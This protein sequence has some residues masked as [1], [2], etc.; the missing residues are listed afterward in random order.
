MTNLLVV[1]VFLL[2][3]ALAGSN[4]TPSFSSTSPSSASFDHCDVEKR[5]AVHGRALHFQ[6]VHH[7]TQAIPDA[8]WDEEFFHH[9]TPHGDLPQEVT[10]RIYEELCGKNRLDVIVAL[11]RP[12][13]ALSAADVLAEAVEAR[14]DALE[15]LEEEETREE[16]SEEGDLLVSDGGDP[17]IKELPGATSTVMPT[18]Q[19]AMSLEIKAP[20]I[21]IYGPVYLGIGGSFSLGS[22]QE[23]ISAGVSLGVQLGVS[24]KIVDLY[25][26]VTVS[27]SAG[28]SGLQGRPPSLGGGLLGTVNYLV[29]DNAMGVKRNLDE[30]V[31]SLIRNHAQDN[32]VRPDTA[33]RKYVEGFAQEYLDVFSDEW[34]FV[35]HTDKQEALADKIDAENMKRIDR[36]MSESPKDVP[37]AEGGI[38]WQFTDVSFWHPTTWGSTKL[39]FRVGADGKT[40]SW[41]PDGSN[42]MPLS[43]VVVKGG[44]YDG[45]R[46]TG[47][48]QK[49]IN[50]LHSVFVKGGRVFNSEQD[51]GEVDFSK[52]DQVE[53]ATQQEFLESNC[54]CSTE[55]FKG[56]QP[57]QEGRLWKTWQ[58][59]KK[60]DNEK[61]NWCYVTGGSK[62]AYA[63]EGAEG[64]WW[65][66]CDMTDRAWARVNQVRR[67]AVNT[68]RKAETAVVNTYHKAG[69]IVNKVV[70]KGAAVV[71][72]VVEKGKNVW[73]DWKGRLSAKGR[74]IWGKT[75]T[76]WGNF[77]AYA[78]AAAD[79]V[80]NTSTYKLLRRELFASST[81]TNPARVFLELANRM[82][83]EG[84]K[85]PARK[86]DLLRRAFLTAN[87]A[88]FDDWTRII[89]IKEA[90][91]SFCVTNKGNAA[92]VRERLRGVM[93][94]FNE[95][96]RH[97]ASAPPG[98][99]AEMRG[100]IQPNMAGVRIEELLRLPEVASQAAGLS[101][102]DRKNVNDMYALIALNLV[103]KFEQITTLARTC[104][105]HIK[106]KVGDTA[107]W[108]SLSPADKL[109]FRKYYRN[110]VNL[111]RSLR[112]TLAE[113]NL[114]D[115]PFARAMVRSLRYIKDKVGPYLESTAAECKK[116][117]RASAPM[118]RLGF[119]VTVG[120][121]L[122]VNLNP[123][124]SNSVG[125]KGGIV[126]FGVYAQVNPTA[127]DNPLQTYKGRYTGYSGSVSFAFNGWSVGL[128]LAYTKHQS[129]TYCQNAYQDNQ[130]SELK[131]TF[132]LGANRGL[133]LSEEAL[134]KTFALALGLGA[135]GNIAGA[136]DRTI[137]G[138]FQALLFKLLPLEFSKKHSLPAGSTEDWNSAMK[139]I[140]S[141][142]H[143]VK[144]YILKFTFIRNEGAGFLLT[145][146]WTFAK[147]P[148]KGA[149]LAS[150][151]VLPA[152]TSKK[153][154]IADKLAQATKAFSDANPLIKISF[155]STVGTLF[156]V[157]SMIPSLTT[158]FNGPITTQWAGD[159]GAN[160][161]GAGN[162]AAIDLSADQDD[163]DDDNHQL[164]LL[165]QAI[166]S[167]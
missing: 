86:A 5:I 164:Q 37:E 33:L 81:P 69:E 144:D 22:S 103:N 54:D 18:L 117:L 114:G 48:N 161:V 92:K 21:P 142:I 68:Y 111:I 49:L 95:K 143:I 76:A 60:W 129:R 166:S 51:K 134:T 126:V 9:M 149:K 145:A 32:G 59:C 70:D 23:S 80:K 141:A 26:F 97:E 15:R 64:R 121:G 102:E 7:S 53:L 127:L 42:W 79:M 151:S 25:A 73:A 85:S 157:T 3:G 160:P 14:E 94:R 159:N 19:S 158:W 98:G 163:D 34:L 101:A 132:T 50:A 137:A 16:R 67:A 44:R 35:T 146:S 130:C 2:A 75:K 52:L 140:G 45:K 78:E 135:V 136:G 91:Y 30:A 154:F 43:T 110:L 65:V 123:A 57:Y 56:Y 93:T 31:N 28:Y 38:V 11:T 107:P 119:D 122:T 124:G 47:E 108:S 8:M 138:P 46:P 90:L 27:G 36:M 115:G 66:K 58:T 17:E 118:M 88:I 150:L 12:G 71:N 20:K 4:H 89:N 109:Q 87:A 29:Y 147:A 100:P 74:A 162:Q 139:A 72:K 24:I 116:K 105:S 153:G 10:D 128:S 125:V 39:W 133:G 62:C 120:I 1:C 167:N 63:L 113:I 77:K 112:Q 82:E 156:K 84:D 152:L 104:G 6:F 99:S 96:F 41:S 40:W 61:F 131:T 106:S 13:D 55:K 83:V 155:T 148:S 165:Q